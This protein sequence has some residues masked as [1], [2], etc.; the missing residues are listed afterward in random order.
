MT[1]NSGNFS[2]YVY[3]DGE[4]LGF[5]RQLDPFELSPGV[6]RLTLRSTATEERE[7]EVA[8]GSGE[9]L[10]VAVELMP[11]PG[12]VFIP[13]AS[14]ANCRASRNHEDL[15]TVGA[16]DR[17]VS[18]PRPDRRTIVV[19]DCGDEGVFSHTF[20]TMRQLNESFPPP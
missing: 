5:T 19:L 14:P 16:L 12:S 9:M 3:E 7:V 18:V 20:E 15:G 17:V 2:A 10:R 13:P 4:K 8:I 1:I 6:H 11:R